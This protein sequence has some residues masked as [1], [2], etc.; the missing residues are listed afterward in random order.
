LQQILG[1]YT[2]FEEKHLQL[3]CLPAIGEQQAADV[4]VYFSGEA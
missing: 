1:C 2:S 4:S 3:H